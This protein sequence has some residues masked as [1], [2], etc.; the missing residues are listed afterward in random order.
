MRSLLLAAAAIVLTESPVLH[1]A[2]PTPLAA[3]PAIE[4]AAVLSHVKTRASD[5]FEGRAPGTAGEEKT[6]A[7]LVE[8][9]RKL[10][11]KPGNPDGTYVQKVP[12]VGITPAPA[13]LTISGGA[14]AAG[15]GPMTLAWRDDVVAWSKRVT[16]EVTVDASEPAAAP[17]RQFD[18]DR[19]G[20]LEEAIAELRT[21]VA[22][23]REQLQAF[24][25][26]FE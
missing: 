6:V 14:G 3:L 17:R 26:Q 10:G 19:V 15:S 20:A 2:D 9:F 12:L 25:R 24:R 8:T 11:L 16:G 22:D 5:A 23:L 18:A 1:A 21:E 4:A 7:Y 13:P